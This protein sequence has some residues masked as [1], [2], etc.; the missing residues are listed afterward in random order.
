MDQELYHYGVPGQKWGVRRN[1]RVLANH[2]RNIAIN[3]AKND[4]RSKRITKSQRK[5][6]IKQA[7]LD[8][9]ALLKSANQK[10]S[11]EEFKAYKKDIKSQTLSEVPHAR[12]KKGATTVNHL[13]TMAEVAGVGAAIGTAGIMGAPV[14]AAVGGAGAASVAVS[15]GKDY[16]I[17]KGI[18]DKIA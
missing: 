15:I 3:D 8:K 5:L 14:L 7:K 6:T 12:L 17:Q 2:R 13:I 10:R 9:K 4:Y 11:K 16:C 18:L 1:L